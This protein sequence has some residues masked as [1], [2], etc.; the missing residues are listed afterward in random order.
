MGDADGSN[1]SGGEAVAPNANPEQR[2]EL[3]IRNRPLTARQSVAFT[4][5]CVLGL[6][7]GLLYTFIGQTAFGVEI[8]VV[9]VLLIVAVLSSLRIGARTD[10]STLNIA[11]GPRRKATVERDDIAEFRLRPPRPSNAARKRPSGPVVQA[12]LKSGAV[13][14][15]RATARRGPNLAVLS[16]AADDVVRRLEAWRTSEV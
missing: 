16:E 4:I 7:L 14:E 13:I 10:G 3:V 12:V 8:L 5:F 11:N 9:L 2:Q 1:R 15:L 6:P